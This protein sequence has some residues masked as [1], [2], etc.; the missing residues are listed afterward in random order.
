MFEDV[1]KD[2]LRI[3]FVFF[4]ACSIIATSQSIVTTALVHI[5]NDFNA[6]STMAQWSYSIFLL[7]L[8]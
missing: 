7:T 1:R 2:Y 8:G 3:L 4:I 5:M 6:S